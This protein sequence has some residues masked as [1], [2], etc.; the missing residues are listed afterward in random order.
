MTAVLWI[1]IRTYVLD[2]QD[3]DPQL[4]VRIRILPSS[5]K[6]RKINLISSVL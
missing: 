3:P 2:I 6:N 5:I 4:Y 1:R